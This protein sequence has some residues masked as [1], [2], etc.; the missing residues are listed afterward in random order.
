M[1]YYYS[2]QVTKNEVSQK[3]VLAKLR[4]N[5]KLPPEW[6]AG[7]WDTHSGWGE[8]TRRSDAY[9][10]KPSHR[11]TYQNVSSGMVCQGTGEEENY[12]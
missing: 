6:P 9:V 12:K 8:A 1:K 3:R 4:N 7:K 11:G 5:E 2:H 10:P